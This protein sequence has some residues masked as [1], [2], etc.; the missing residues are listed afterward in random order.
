MQTARA[1][2]AAMALAAAIMPARAAVA[3]D[4]L[5]PYQLVRSLQIVQDQIADGDHAALP[6]QQRM[7]RMI[8]QR[9]GESLPEDFA[10]QRNFRALMMY[11]MSGGN[12]R[13][14][15]RLLDRLVLEDRDARLAAG[16]VQYLKGNP[17]GALAAL[18]EI[19]PPDVA[20]ELSPFLALVK[21]TVI[22]GK[23]PEK[24]LALLDQA[25]LLGP[26][27]LIEEAALRRSMVL[28]T[29]L[30]RPERFLSASEQYARRFLRSPYASQFADSF[31]A[32]VAEL[33]AALNLDGVVEVIAEMTP[34]QSKVIYL[35]IARRAAIDRTD[36]L[37]A[38]A[39]GGLEAG[40]DGAADDP[41]AE[42]YRALAEVASEHPEAVRERMSV[43]DRKA[44]SGSDRLLLDAALAI[45]ADVVRPVR[46]A[47]P[48]SPAQAVA[49]MPDD[50]H[51]A[52][53]DDLIDYAEQPLNEEPAPVVVAADAE[54]GA[55]EDE[56][57]SE[58][59]RRLAAIDQ[60]LEEK[61]P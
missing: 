2:L 18:A 52:D 1:H 21:G 50:D 7:I 26:G 54:S 11:A 12:P 17:G 5:A 35:R 4:E 58:T 56:Y 24:S 37:L 28:A 49:D 47:A 10:D 40:P 60:L 43:I 30:R 59:R 55:D 20:A 41:R 29:Q 53:A 44:L 33:H 39:T 25:R 57:V 42:L 15:E 9:L 16:L 23:D 36:D 22:A 13:T 45:V 32:G 8:D 38:F 34:E 27:T 31:V 48:E 3:S 6:M 46:A 51:Q 19:E 14:V 61:S